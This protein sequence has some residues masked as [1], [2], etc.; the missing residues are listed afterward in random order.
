MTRSKM[1]FI[2]CACTLLA[3]QCAWGQQEE[4]A[5]PAQEGT[6]APG[7]EPSEP[8]ITLAPDKRPLSGVEE[9]QV[10]S[11]ARARNF[12]VPSLRITA[13][14]DSNRTI[15]STGTRGYELNGSVVG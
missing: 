10:E 3:A 2:V 15:S 11:P 5:P 7:A 9:L 6:P 14:G 12:V 4:P 13:F 8:S 1:L